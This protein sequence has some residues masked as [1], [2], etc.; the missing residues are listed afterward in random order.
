MSELQVAARLQQLGLLSGRGEAPKDDEFLRYARKRLGVPSWGAATEDGE[1][2]ANDAGDYDE[3]AESNDNAVLDAPA[4]SWNPS[5]S[6]LLGL[7]QARELLL[8]ATQAPLS[9]P[10]Q[11]ELASQLKTS[12][13]V[14]TIKSIVRPAQL[15]G[16]VENNPLVATEL[17]LRLLSPGPGDSGSSEG[18]GGSEAAANGGSS[19]AKAVAQSPSSATPTAAAATASDANGNDA[20][21]SSSSSALSVEDYLST[22]STMELSLHSIDVVN[23][24]ATVTTL[25]TG[26][27]SKFINYCITSCENIKD[28]YMQNRLVRLVCV[29]VQSLIRNKVVSVRDLC[30]EAQSFCVEFSRIREAAGLYRLLKSFEGQGQGG[31]SPGGGGSASK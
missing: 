22:L 2:L 6:P 12:F 27:F 15:S 17:L 13:S 11:Q 4:L 20:T 24:L 26:F 14:E 9:P 30:V 28:K 5:Q 10:S 19:S 31:A 29:F 18:G 7:D 16:L 3:F 8:S 23:R 1:E 25:P 21:S